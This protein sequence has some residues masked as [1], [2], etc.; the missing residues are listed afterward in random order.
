MYISVPLRICYFYISVLRALLRLFRKT[1]KIDKFSSNI[2][3]SKELISVCPF[4][5]IGFQLIRAR[6]RSL[7]R[8]KN[9]YTMCVTL[10][11]IQYSRALSVALERETWYLIIIRSLYFDSN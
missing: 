4:I 7:V 9:S 8:K 2:Y 10:Q 5:E 1:K 3:A 11:K 6:V